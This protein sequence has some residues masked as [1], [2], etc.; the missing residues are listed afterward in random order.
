LHSFIAFLVLLSR[1]YNLAFWLQFLTN[2]LTYLSTWDSKTRTRTWCPR[3]RT[4][5]RTWN[6]VP[7]NPQGQGQGL[8]DKNTVC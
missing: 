1:L 7:E 3:T 2:L 8:E 4:R 5:K 6:L